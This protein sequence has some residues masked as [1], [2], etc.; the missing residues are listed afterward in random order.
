M[1]ERRSFEH[2]TTDEPSRHDRWSCCLCCGYPTL[3]RPNDYETCSLCGWF[4]DYVDEHARG[5][6]LA[7]ARENFRAR[8]TTHRPGTHGFKRHDADH[9]RAVKRLLIRAYDEYMAEPDLHR[10]G[11]LYA[12][13]R[14][15]EDLLPLT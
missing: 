7:E 6:S 14:R 15:L 8:L 13:A 11:S 10:R 4:D 12:N 3:G 1:S 9:D 5:T 2:F